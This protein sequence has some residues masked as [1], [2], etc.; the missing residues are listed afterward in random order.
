MI[1]AKEYQSMLEGNLEIIKEQINGVSDSEMLIQPPN[2]GNCL[3]WILGHLPESMISIL[4]F[5]GGEK[6]PERR[7]NYLLL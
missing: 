6:P 4:G 3:L 5:L 1:T 7:A 2:G